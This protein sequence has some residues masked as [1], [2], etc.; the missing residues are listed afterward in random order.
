MT[1]TTINPILVTRLTREWN[2]AIRNEERAIERSASDAT[3]DRC[4]RASDRARRALTCAK[5]GLPVPATKAPRTA[6][7]LGKAGLSALA[8]LGRIVARSVARQAALAKAR[9]AAVLARVARQARAAFR[10]ALRA[11]VALVTKEIPVSKTNPHLGTSTSPTLAAG[12]VYGTISATIRVTDRHGHVHTLTRSNRFGL[13]VV[14]KLIGDRF[15]FSGGI[16]GEHCIDANAAITDA[17][18]L[19][20]H[21]AGYCTN[22]GLRDWEVLKIEPTGEG[23]YRF[24][25]EGFNWCTQEPFSW[26]VRD[27]DDERYGLDAIGADKLAQLGLYAQA[28]Q[29]VAS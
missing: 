10:R 16:H 3:L 4:V 23:Y 13:T 2:R 6:R 24:A 20:A 26:R 12:I 5:A 21:W 27:L 25:I 14:C 7:N 11:V 17:T 19:L 8:A 22:N 28:A 1:T 9:A 18:R 29:A 15:V